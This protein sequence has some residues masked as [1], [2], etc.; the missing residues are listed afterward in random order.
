MFGFFKNI[1]KIRLSDTEKS[2][3]KGDR[4]YIAILSLFAVVII[5]A[6]V[7][8]SFDPATA[9]QIKNLKISAFDIIIFTAAITGYFITKKR[10]KK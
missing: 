10:G 5:F 4:A 9:Q 2:E 6:L 3:Q 7:R 8:A 1:P